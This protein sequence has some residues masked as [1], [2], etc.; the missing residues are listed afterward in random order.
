MSE[1]WETGYATPEEASL[2]DIPPQFVTVVGTR[3]DGDYATV[4]LLTND[5]P[6]FEDYQVNCVRDKGRW[7]FESGFP[8][9]AGVPEEVLAEARALGWTGDWV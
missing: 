7:H 8:F 3:I 1:D 2:G 9:G 6:P 4:W 5:T